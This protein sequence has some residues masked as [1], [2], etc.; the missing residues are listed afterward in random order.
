[1]GQ[2]K[3]ESLTD[4]LRRVIPFYEAQPKDTPGRLDTL[5]DIEL[6]LY[7]FEFMTEERIHEILKP[8]AE[9]IEEQIEAEAE[10]VTYLIQVKI[11]TNRQTGKIEEVWVY[12]SL[13]C[14]NY[15]D[16]TTVKG[17][18][19]AVSDFLETYHRIGEVNS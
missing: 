17:I 4:K 19:E 3:S 14:C 6:H 9:Q 11:N 18:G 1:M 2:N 7:G 16:S 13:N 10:T 15:M 5:T 12:D 8:Y